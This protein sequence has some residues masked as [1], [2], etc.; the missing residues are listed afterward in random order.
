MNWSGIDLFC[1]PLKWITNSELL[2]REIFFEELFFFLFAERSQA[3]IVNWCSLTKLPSDF[4][5]SSPSNPLRS[6]IKWEKN[7]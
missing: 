6:L 4:V 3:C 2:R 5:L 1:L 7:R